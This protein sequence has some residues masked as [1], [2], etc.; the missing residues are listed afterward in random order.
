MGGIRRYLKKKQKFC[1]SDSTPKDN[2]SVSSEAFQKGDEFIY[3]AWQTK[4]RQVIKT[5]DRA[6]S[7]DA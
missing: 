5:L 7:D 1:R 6:F 3:D 2:F 4:S